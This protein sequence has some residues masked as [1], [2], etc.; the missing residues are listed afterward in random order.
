ME[1]QYLELVDVLHGLEKGIPARDAVLKFAEV[2]LQV[3]RREGS[4]A[5]SYCPLPSNCSGQ[6][7]A[8]CNLSKFLARSSRIG[9]RS[10]HSWKR[11]WDGSLEG[12]G[13]GRLR[14][15][16][17]DS[18]YACLPLPPLQCI[19]LEQAK[20]ASAEARQAVK[21]LVCLLLWL[22]RWLLRC[23]CDGGDRVHA[24]CPTVQ[25][26]MVA[27]HKEAL[28]HATTASLGHLKAVEAKYQAQKVWWGW[29]WG[30]GWGGACRR[31]RIWADHSLHPP[32]SSRHSK[33]EHQH[34]VGGQDC[35][36]APRPG[37]CAGGCRPASAR[38]GR[39]IA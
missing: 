20:Y 38:A 19:E 28:E 29:G 8:R 33:T 22:L 25:E 14:S 5:L 6:N 37:G 36:A 4:S 9:R 32:P 11:R 24:H 1:Q 7:I 13:M 12:E 10:S 30:W 34:C 2:G 35:R 39:G 17:S 18:T 21:D 31:K 27:T 15:R 3:E 26:E 16:T 23:G